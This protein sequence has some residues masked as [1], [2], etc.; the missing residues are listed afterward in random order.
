MNY[1]YEAIKPTRLYI[2]QCPHCGMK[3]FGKH[4]GQ[5]IEIYRG[6]G[7]RWNNH[8]SYHN[9]DP[10]HLWNSDWYHDTTIS[11]FALKFSHINKIVESDDW[12]NLKPENGLDGGFDHLNDGSEKHSE[13]ARKGALSANK[14]GANILGGIKIKKMY[15]TGTFF[16]KKHD[17]ET[18]KKISEKTKLNGGEKL[19]HWKGY[20]WINNGSHQKRIKDD[21]IPEGWVKGGLSKTRR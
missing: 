1:L 19:A 21:P 12:A 9:V 6:S 18:C 15:P 10:I 4:T 13:R 14:N 5:D 11:R 16:D 17:E 7:S 2:K 3:Y 20:F 8:I